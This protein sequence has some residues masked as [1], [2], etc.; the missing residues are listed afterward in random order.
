MLSAQEHVSQL[1][2]FIIVITT[3]QAQL[4]HCAN[5]LLRNFKEHNV[6]RFSLFLCVLQYTAM[7]DIFSHGSKCC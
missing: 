5:Y 6:V 4:Q 1:K 2:Y 7:Y 3:K